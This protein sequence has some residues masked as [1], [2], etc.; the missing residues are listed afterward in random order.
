MDGDWNVTNKEMHKMLLKLRLNMT[1]ADLDLV[2]AKV[3]HEK[4]T[5]SEILC[6]PKLFSKTLAWHSKPAT[7]PALRR[8]LDLAKEHRAQVCKTLLQDSSC[9][10]VCIHN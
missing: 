1:R 3:M 6:D 2:I 8:A 7:A 9:K 10:T 4:D 5:K